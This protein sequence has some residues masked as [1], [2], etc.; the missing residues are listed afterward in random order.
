M[1]RFL[2]YL[3]IL[4]GKIDDYIHGTHIKPPE[5][6]EFAFSA[7]SEYTDDALKALD[8]WHAAE[9]YFNSINDPDLVEYA[10]YEL[11]A[12]RRKYEYLMRKLRNGDA[13]WEQG[14][15]YSGSTYR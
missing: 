14:N 7:V 2:D 5:S 3:S 11:E 9:N 6:G 1:S 4:N 8:E 13:A 15:S 12:A 10:L